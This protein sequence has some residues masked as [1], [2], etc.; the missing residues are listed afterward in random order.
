MD[1]SRCVR[2]GHYR[3]RPDL[4]VPAVPE[5]RALG[6]DFDHTL[7]IDNK[8]ERVAF[9]RLSEYAHAGG[10]RALGTLAQE[11]R[12]IDALLV[13]QRSGALTI[14]EAVL[15][16]LAERGCTG[17]DR[18]VELYKRLALDSVEQFVVPQPDIADVLQ[19]LRGR[20]VPYAILTNGWSPLQER[21]AQRVSFDGPVIVSSRLRAQKPAAEAFAA[22]ARVLGHAAEQVAYVGDSP[23]ADIAGARAAGMTGV[24]LDAEGVSYP[25][26]LAPPS[27]VIHTL[28][29]LLTLV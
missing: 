15:R 24:W 1:R 10:C 23:A 12:C 11:I 26:E 22:L 9:L 17:G 19:A 7:G 29:E 2:S 25:A 8:L 3:P 28:T 21:K 4:T 13:E 6:F 5:I 20:G 16:F 14:E 18:F 27:I